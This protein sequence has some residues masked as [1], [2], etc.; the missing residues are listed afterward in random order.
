MYFQ[1]CGLRATS[2]LLT[3]S[4]LESMPSHASL[5]WSATSHDQRQLCARQRYC[6]NQPPPPPSPRKHRYRS[7]SAPEKVVKYYMFSVSVREGIEVGV[8]K[9]YSA[10]RRRILRKVFC[11]RMREVSVWYDAIR[12]WC[13]GFA[14][15]GVLE[16]RKNYYSG[17]VLW[18]NS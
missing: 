1:C 16:Q 5:T 6:Y 11:L 15:P 9:D 8:W 17:V 2:I 18:G 10:F 14:V 7:P 12:C 4:R 13:F 3:L